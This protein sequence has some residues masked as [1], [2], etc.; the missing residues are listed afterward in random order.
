E[1]YA[2]FNSSTDHVA[3]YTVLGI[4]AAGAAAKLLG[5]G[6]FLVVLLKFGKFLIIPII[7]G[8]KYIVKGCRWV[9]GKVT[10]QKPAPAAETSAQIAETPTAP[11]QDPPNA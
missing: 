4:V 8:W 1:T 2:D 10:G 7:A 6:A 9:W 3:E 5:K 11:P